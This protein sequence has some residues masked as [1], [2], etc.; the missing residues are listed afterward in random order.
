MWG[1]QQGMGWWMLF[2]SFWTLLFWGATI[3]LVVCGIRVLTGGNK[4]PE[5]EDPLKIA[6]RRYAR[7]EISRAEVEEIKATLSAK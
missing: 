3:A 7:G 4:P 2:G 6:Q 5:G 1:M